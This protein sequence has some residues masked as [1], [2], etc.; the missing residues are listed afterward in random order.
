MFDGDDDRDRFIDWF[1]EKRAE[2]G[3][4]F[5]A[6]DRSRYA[7]ALLQRGEA[8]CPRCVGT[9]E[10]GGRHPCPTCDGVG[11]VKGYGA[12]SWVSVD[13]P[14]YAGMVGQV[15][16]ILFEMPVRPLFAVKLHGTDTTCDVPAGRL[17]RAGRPA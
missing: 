13:L 11:R 12:G 14:E 15:V 2:A 10:A 7:E 3:F 1:E 17:R 6:H 16:E 8:V 5:T 4:S 9:K